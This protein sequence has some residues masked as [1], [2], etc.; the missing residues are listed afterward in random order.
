MRC[1]LCT[2]VLVKPSRQLPSPVDITLW[3]LMIHLFTG[4]CNEYFKGRVPAFAPLMKGS[5]QFLTFHF[6]TVAV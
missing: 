5:I 1:T 4:H 2:G 6:L 3:M